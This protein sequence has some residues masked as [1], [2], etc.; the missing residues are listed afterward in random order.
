MSSV[1]APIDRPIE[2][3]NYALNA[4]RIIAALVVVVSHVRP[5]F[6]EDFSQAQNPTLLVQALYAVTSLGHEAVVVFFVLS[7]Y[8]VGGSVTRSVLGARFD[9]RAY[10]VARL[11]RL[12]LVL[13]PAIALTQALDRVGVALSPHSDIYTGDPGYHTVVPVG[14]PLPNLGASDTLGNL[15]FLQRL[16]VPA[17]GTNTPLWSLAAEFWY[18][19][20]FPAVLVAI[21]PGAAL[22]TRVVAG[23][24]GV[25]GLV[26]VSLPNQ[27]DPT[28]VL[29]LFPTW[30]AGAAIA[31]QR[32]R[33][34]RG[35]EW[36]GRRLAFVQLALVAVVLLAA[37]WASRA[38]SPISTFVLALATAFMLASLIPDVRSRAMKRTLAPLSWSAE[39]S[40]SLYA[41]HL[42][43]LALLAAL[44][45]PNIESRWSMTPLSFALLLAI[46]LVPVVVAIGMFYAA[47]KH[48]SRVRSALTGERAGSPRATALRRD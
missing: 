12:W 3:T 10:A 15:A 47:E 42:P 43:V 31:W 19:L 34:L 29:L 17:L 2:G 4:V 32:D 45:L 18:Y 6:F 46:T 11:V 21:M 23:L 27:E 7:G 48:T 44:I 41:T 36:L 16:Y 26:V 35:I 9:P 14:G 24:V 39:W 22:K 5:L 8:W 30:L 38:G 25:G 1:S 37:I 28:Q 20:L 40:Y 13:I 33:V